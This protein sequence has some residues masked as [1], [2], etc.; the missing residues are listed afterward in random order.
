[1]S[2]RVALIFGPAKLRLPL[3]SSSS[4]KLCGRMIKFLV[5]FWGL[6]INFTTNKGIRIDSKHGHGISSSELRYAT[7][8]FL[9]YNRKTVLI[10]SNA[11]TLRT[12]VY[13]DTLKWSSSRFLPVQHLHAINAWMSSHVDKRHSPT[14]VS[15]TNSSQR[16]TTDDFFQIMHRQE[17]Q[18]SWWSL[19]KIPVAC[20]VLKRSPRG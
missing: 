9:E 1:M 10:V 18:P 6:P 20:S 14:T 16:S 11:T 5:Y 3:P 2:E 7:T 15:G 12:S 13:C 17:C 8:A 4:L 19:A